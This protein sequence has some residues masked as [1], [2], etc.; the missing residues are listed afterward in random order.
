MATSCTGMLHGGEKSSENL[1][2]WA[3]RGILFCSDHLTSFL[4]EEITLPPDG[5]SY[6]SSAS[7][8]R[9]FMALARRKD[10]G[11]S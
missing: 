7:L 10:D 3:L 11:A 5:F 9:L 2:D 6:R 4:R 1:G 8:Q